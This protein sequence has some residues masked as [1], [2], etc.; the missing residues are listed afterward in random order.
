MDNARVGS[1]N[2]LDWTDKGE[3]CATLSKHMLKMENW[4]IGLIWQILEDARK[5]PE[6]MDINKL[7]EDAMSIAKD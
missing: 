7:H 5:D 1:L 2:L 3:A 4:Q 6:E